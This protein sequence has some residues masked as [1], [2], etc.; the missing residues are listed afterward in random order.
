MWQTINL[1]DYVDSSLIDIETVKFNLSAWLGGFIH[2][3]DTATI[4]LTFLNQANQM[5][6]NVSS[7]GPVDNVDRSNV[8]S[9]LFRQTTGV[10]PAGARSVT[11]LV[12]IARTIGPINDGYA[13]NI[14]VFL[15]Q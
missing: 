1:N 15:Y 11:V 10:V 12:L 8:T 3:N 5:V 14:G 7:I 2:Q 4:S 9:F 6:G 13:D